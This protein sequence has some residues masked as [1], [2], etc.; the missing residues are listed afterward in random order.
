MAKTMGK[1]GIYSDF[2]TEEAVHAMRLGAYDAF[3]RRKKLGLPIYGWDAERECVVEIP[4]EEIVVPP[5]HANDHP[6]PL[7]D[8]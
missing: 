5:E 3:R 6:F 1:S 8:H 7:N 4:A 2:T